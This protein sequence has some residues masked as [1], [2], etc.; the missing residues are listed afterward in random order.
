[1]K[2]IG[3][4]ITAVLFCV[5]GGVASAY[6]ELGEEGGKPEQN[7]PEKQQGKRQQAKPTKQ[8]DQ[9]QQQRAQQQPSRLSAERQQQL[10]V[11]QQ[12]RSAQYRQQ[13]GQQG[14]LEPPRIALL[15]HQ[16]RVSQLRVEQRYSARWRQ[17]RVRIEKDR[18]DYDR[19]PYY[20]TAP[21][22]RYARGGN[23][24][25]TNQYGADLLRRAVNCGYAEGFRAGEADRQDAWAPNYQ[26]SYAYEDANF[27]YNGY[28]VEQ[29]DY[30]FYFR[31]GFRRGYEDGYNSRHQYGRYSNGGYSVL[32]NTLSLILRLE[33]LH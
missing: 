19:D 11:Q 22:F 13:L 24:Y 20:Y 26:E 1:M 5:F 31:E 3:M 16:K 12:Q 9:N 23:Y 27:G 18:H 33:S 29:D 15:H 28:Y 14:Q 32:G 2:R 6:P 25:E 8:Q 7:Q 17:Q 4:I 10:I 21:S 30:S